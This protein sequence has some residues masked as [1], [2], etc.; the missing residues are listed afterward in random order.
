[1]PLSQ[2]LIIKTMEYTFKYADFSIEEGN[3]MT[4]KRRIQETLKLLQNE[5]GLSYLKTKN[6]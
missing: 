6:V 3:S 2:W 1:M 4:L 5:N